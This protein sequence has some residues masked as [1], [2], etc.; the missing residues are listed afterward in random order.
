MES[1]LV[2]VLMPSY[3]HASYVE[4]AVR[5]VF[6]QTWKNLEL[7][8]V[9]DGSRD[10]SVLR[11]RRLLA[12]APIPMQVLEGGHR[13][14][15]GALNLAVRSSRGEYLSILASDDAYLPQKLELQMGLLLKNP[16]APLV[17]GEFE[18]MDS[19]GQRTGRL[20]GDYLPALARG[21]AL[22]SLLL[23]QSEVRSVAILM[24]RSELLAIGGYDESL[25]AEDWQTILPLAAR[26]P[27]LA[28]DE[29]VVLRR[30]HGENL[31]TT[32]VHQ[33]KTFS[34]REELLLHILEQVTPPTLDVSQVAGLHAAIS[35]RNA[36]ASG[37]WAKVFDGLRQT[38]VRFPESR[39]RILR[40]AA[41]GGV[42]Y[43][44]IHLLKPRLS[45]AVL[46]QVEPGKQLLRRFLRPRL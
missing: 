24:R 22:E 10:D 9:D 38:L 2:S 5:S 46:A 35:L 27:F 34:L 42:S 45:P 15:C 26:G 39:Q 16:K 8:V 36:A 18:V 41:I 37:A 23:L 12:Q 21:D 44:W 14:L 1:P 31:T 29:P 25:R 7:V 4:Q 13:G 11:L 28:V 40:E 19:N 30:I 20:G 32:G 3:N 43:S 6:Q 17:H 33:K